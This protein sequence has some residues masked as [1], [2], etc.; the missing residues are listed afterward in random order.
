MPQEVVV[1]AT[2]TLQV[3]HCLEALEQ[4]KEITKKIKSGLYTLYMRV[5]I[6]IKRKPG[7]KQMRTA[8]EATHYINSQ[9]VWG[10]SPP[11]FFFKGLV[12]P[13]CVGIS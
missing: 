6:D 11:P 8:Y 3:S 5:Y 2:E 9:L 10:G 4:C 13:L 12:F 7:G 1:H